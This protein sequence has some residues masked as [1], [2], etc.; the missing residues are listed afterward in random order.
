MKGK[1][2]FEKRCFNDGAKTEDNKNK[3]TKKK[4]Q[5]KQTEKLLYTQTKA[6][7]LV[8]DFGK[9]RRDFLSLDLVTHSS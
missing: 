1:V 2:H 7:A 3:K 4:E 9:N 8:I 5:K 6:N